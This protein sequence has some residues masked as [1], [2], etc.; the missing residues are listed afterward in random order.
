MIYEVSGNSRNGVAHESSPFH[1]LL[2]YVNA[3][4]L[5]IQDTLDTFE[6]GAVAARQSIS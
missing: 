2:M 5:N 4:A 6:R 1:S 3:T